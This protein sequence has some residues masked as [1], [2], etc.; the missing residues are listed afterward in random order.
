MA[1]EVGYAGVHDATTGEFLAGT[2][3]PALVKLAKDGPVLAAPGDNDN[4]VPVPEGTVLH[5]TGARKVTV[6]SATKGGTA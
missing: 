2:A 5:S 3:D 6:T 1:Q 4:W